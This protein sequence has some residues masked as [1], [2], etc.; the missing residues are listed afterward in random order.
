MAIERRLF[1]AYRNANRSIA[2]VAVSSSDNAVLF[3]LKS[4]S[5]RV[6]RPRWRSGWVNWRVEFW[7]FFRNQG[8]PNSGGRG[9][10]GALF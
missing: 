3:S 5:F 9:E 8:V 2:N 7:R 4:R 1:G 6:F 10:L